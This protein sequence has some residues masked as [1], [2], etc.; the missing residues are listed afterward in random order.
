MRWPLFGSEFSKY[1]PPCT[2][3]P[4]TVTVVSFA[5]STALVIRWL[6]VAM[7]G[8]PTP[9]VEPSGNPETCT[10]TAGGGGGVLEVGADVAALL[11]PL[12]LAAE[13]PA[14]VTA[15]TEP[16]PELELEQALARTATAAT[17]TAKSLAADVDLVEITPPR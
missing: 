14:L 11:P 10:F 9:T 12:L 16:L 7:M 8:I 15:P 13:E 5:N 6:K 17:A 4:F 1:Q 3:V 2:G